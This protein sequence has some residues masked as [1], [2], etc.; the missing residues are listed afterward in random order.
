[1]TVTQEVLDFL[2]MRIN[3]HL[4]GF[5]GWTPICIDG[6]AGSGKTTLAAQL[7]PLLPA[8]VIH[9]DDLYNGWDGIEEGITMLHS[10]ILEPLS[11]GQP[12][13]YSRY[14]WMA[15]TYLERHRVPLSDFLVV[16]G[17]GSACR[18]VDQWK[19]FIIWVEADDDERLRR[20]LERDGA[21]A[22]PQ[23][24][25]FMETERRLYQQ[26]DTVHR[27]HIRL[28]GVGRIMADR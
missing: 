7:A 20:G 18:Q 26:H 19:P 13:K 2:L 9:M 12:G 3:D 21:D 1:M 17:C 11:Q 10:Q 8:Q 23:W 5:G 14:D 24:R 16:E 4:D 28:D 15:G 6:P 27:A 25:A 22:E